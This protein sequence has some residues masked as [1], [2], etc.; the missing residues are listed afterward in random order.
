MT[1]SI[2]LMAVVTVAILAVP[3]FRAPRAA[4]DVGGEQEERHRLF[5]QLADLEYDFYMDKISR[6][7]YEQLR[8]Q[9]L[10]Q[11]TALLAESEEVEERLRQEIRAE[12][13]ARLEKR[14]HHG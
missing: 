8:R 2:V 4:D 1:V 5:A 9:L 12:V 14:M 11:L 10:G 3:F 6:Q 13:Q 7:D